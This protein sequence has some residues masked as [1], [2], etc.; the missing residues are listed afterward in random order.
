MSNCV[1][2]FTTKGVL[3]IGQRQDKGQGTKDVGGWNRH[4]GERGDHL[5]LVLHLRPRQVAS[6]ICHAAARKK[7][8]RQLE[9]HTVQIGVC[10]W[11]RRSDRASEICCPLPRALPRAICRASRYDSA[12]SW[13]STTRTSSF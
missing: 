1:T 7:D 12:G 3:R 8:Q 10:R 9:I 2:D 6:E 13:I 5:A 11:P 4:H